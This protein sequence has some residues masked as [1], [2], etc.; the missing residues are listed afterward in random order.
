MKL[1]GKRTMISFAGLV[2]LAIAGFAQNAEFPGARNLVQRVQEDMRRAADFARQTPAI[3]KDRKQIERWDNAQRSMSE[4]DKHLSKGKFDKGELDGAINDL[5]NVVDHN[6]LSSEDR[7]VLNR[8]LGD[9]RQF[10][11]N[12]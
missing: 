6:T 10:R 9:L 3:H 2:C 7:D 8:D 4:F 5:K 12:R 1:I 11:S